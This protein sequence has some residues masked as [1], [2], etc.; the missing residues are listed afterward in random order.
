[1]PL[2]DGTRSPRS[3]SAVRSRRLGWWWRRRPRSRLFLSL[4]SLLVGL[5]ILSIPFTPWILYHV[6]TPEPSFPYPTKLAGTSLLPDVP[7]AIKPLPRENRLVIP[8]IGVDVEVVEGQD[9][10]AL[11]RGIW[12]LPQTSSPDR[13][14]NTVLTG[15]RFQYLA[16]PRTLYLLDQLVEGDL[17]IIYWQGVEYD[18]R[19]FGRRVVNPDAVEILD[20]TPKPQLTIFTCTPVFSTKQRL[21]LF[22]EPITT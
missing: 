20:N 4:T 14:G 13:G 12:H 2:R 18:Y 16:G 3:A 15:H 9:E 1:M 22:A 21:V 6:F 7:D 8:K 10:R 19:V 5:V 11:W 17:I